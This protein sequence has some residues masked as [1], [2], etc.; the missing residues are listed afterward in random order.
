VLLT[1]LEATRDGPL[2]NA[3]LRALGTTGS[4]RALLPL[5]EGLES[6]LPGRRTAARWGLRQLARSLAPD[7]RAVGPLAAALRTRRG[8]QE[9]IELLELFGRWGGTAALE[10]LLPWLS[11]SAE[12]V[13]RAALEA[14]ARVPGRP[15]PLLEVLEHHPDPSVRGAAAVALGRGTPP[16]RLWPLVR[17]RLGD[18]E[19]TDR[20]AWLLA[21]LGSLRNAPA[22]AQPPPDLYAALGKLLLEGSRSQGRLALEGLR[23]LGDRDA[24]G[25]LRAALRAP[26]VATP[27]APA[28]RRVLGALGHPL[29]Q[30]A[31]D[32]EALADWL[33]GAALAAPNS[34]PGTVQAALAALEAPWPARGAA[35]AVLAGAAEAADEA[36]PEARLCSRLQQATDPVLLADLALWAGAGRGRCGPRLATWLADRL[37]R[38][39]SELL[40]RTLAEALWR[41]HH[42]GDALATEALRACVVEPPPALLQ[43]GCGPWAPAEEDAPTP[44][45]VRLAGA[46]GPLRWLVLR[47]PD[48]RLVPV[49]AAAGET[50][51]PTPPARPL[52]AFPLA[53]LPDAPR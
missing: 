8:E 49:R 28:L 25:R 43:A 34:A 24:I 31:P 32:A 6:D 10:P 15:A 48:G 41:R 40:A 26:A 45:S 42:T 35:A 47:L 1:L 7:D 50:L 52:E 30:E 9:R 3:L 14:L 38:A 36:L 53:T 21:L 16:E 2:G 27:L 37:H 51:V 22:Q 13:R 39:R 12:R 44:A 17:V 19:P 18:P 11:D 46:G 23:L 4:D 20:H 5:L 29:P 33:G